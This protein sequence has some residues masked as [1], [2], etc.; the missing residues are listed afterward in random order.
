MSQPAD[1]AKPAFRV[2]KLR[3]CTRPGDKPGR[4]VPTGKALK[5]TG[6][7]ANSTKANALKKKGQKII[8]EDIPTYDISDIYQKHASFIGR[9]ITRLTGYGPHVDD[10]LQETFIVA[11]KKIHT[12]EGRAKVS[13]W[14]Y[15]IAAN[16]CMHH[17]RSQ[18]RRRLFKA[19]W[20]HENRGS[21]PEQPDRALDRDQK[22]AL[23]HEILEQLPF[24]QREVFVLYELEELQGET[25]AEIIGIPVGTVWTRL[26]KARKIFMQSARRKMAK[27]KHP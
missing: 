10:L 16:H 2:V 23:V 26:R 9:V 1:F 17:Q 14:L 15:R 5:K 3:A 24:K 22:I 13:S 18:K 25:I 12:F 7:K 21:L 11:H 6:P 27:E 20:A 19:R 8:A 4:K